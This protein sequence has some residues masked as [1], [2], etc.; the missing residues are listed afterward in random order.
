M[1]NAPLRRLFALLAAALIASPALVASS[2]FAQDEDTPFDPQQC[3]EGTLYT[4]PVQDFSPG[5]E[6]RLR[7]SL[8][9]SSLSASIRENLEA[10]AEYYAFSLTD[11]AYKTAPAARARDLTRKWELSNVSD[12]ARE[13]L[14]GYLVQKLRVVLGQCD[15]GERMAAIIFLSM[16]DSEKYD[17]R[18]RKPAVPYWPTGDVYLDVIENPN[19]LAMV[20]IRAAQ[21]LGRLLAYAEAP[22]VEYDRIYDRT[23]GALLRYLDGSLETQNAGEGDWW[24]AYHLAVAL[25]KSQQPTNLQLDPVG[26]Q[27]LLTIVG[28][29]EQPDLLRAKALRSLSTTPWSEGNGFDIEP[30][31]KAQV[32]FAQD[33]AERYNA[34]PTFWQHRHVAADLY[35][36]FKPETIEQFEAGEGW[37]AQTKQSSNRGAVG[38]VE[39]AFAVIKP[40]FQSI[41]RTEGLSQKPLGREQ[42]AALGEWLGNNPPGGSVHPRLGEIEFQARPAPENATAA[43]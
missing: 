5:G 19:E 41:V 39:S 43:N 24:L 27:A 38:T 15:V 26:P 4:Q 20:K 31:V 6:R 14:Q 37:L 8:K 1:P 21:S 18:E 30:I 3:S 7:D 25:G 9:A 29:P 17:L 33:W 32:Q 40:I 12:E 23:A 11:P 13:A 28:D 35:F 2:A 34:D 42:V 16:I 10:A 36:S 22:Q